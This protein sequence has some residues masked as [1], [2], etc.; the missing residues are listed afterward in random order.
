MLAVALV[1][2][3]LQADSYAEGLKALEEGKYQAAVGAFQKALESDPK[4]YTALFNLGLAYGFLNRDADA[5]TAYRKVLELK[6]KLYEAEL[7]AGILLMR[8]KQPAAALPLFEDAAAQ[9]PAEFRPRHYLARAQL[10]TGDYPQAE[11]NYRRALELDPKFAEA[12]LGLAHALSSQAKLAEAAPHFRKAAQ[13]DPEYR[14]YLLELGQLYEKNRQLDEAIAVYRE[15]PEDASAQEHLGTLLLDSRKYAEAIPPLE[16]AYRIGPT[17]ANRAALAAACLFAGQTDR[18]LP[19][20]EQAVAAEPAQAD[21]RM[22]YGRALRDQ[23][24][25]PAAAAQFQEAARLKPSDAKTWN[26]LGAVSYL[27][28]SLEDAL[29]AFDKA[30]E[31]GDNTPGNWFLRAIILDKAKQLK[32]ALEAYQRFLSLSDGKS[33]DQEFQARQ[34]ARILQRELEKR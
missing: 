24:K 19:L 6:P 18:A 11:A 21:L 29:A 10:E 25:Y 12:E 7:N 17:N 27:A 30:R 5:L 20:L 33:P 8:G 32:P 9:K 28:G 23:K 3:L 34:R 4:D 26:E 31:L 14:E 1:C 13:L 2:C 16:T 15:F 22:M